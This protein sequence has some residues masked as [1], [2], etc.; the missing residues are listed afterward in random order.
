MGRILPVHKFRQGF[1]EGLKTHD[2]CA[3]DWEVKSRG[4]GDA[5]HVVTVAAACVF[6]NRVDFFAKRILLARK[7]QRTGPKQQYAFPSLDHAGNISPLAT[8][9][10]TPQ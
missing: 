1:A 7:L 5:F 4:G 2:V 3:F 9:S 6:E 8:H 10:R